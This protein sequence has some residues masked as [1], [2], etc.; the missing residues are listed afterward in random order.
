MTAN[1]LIQEFVD[2]T[3]FIDTHEHIIEET[4]RLVAPNPND[5]RYPCDD[6]AYLFLHYSA[7]DLTSVGMT[8][9]DFARFYGVE[10]TPAEKWRLFE[11]Y[12]ARAKNTGYLQAVRITVRELFGEEDVSA[13]SVERITE[14]MRTLVK[15]GYYRNVLRDVANVDTCQVNSL[16]HV[17][18]E[19]QYPDLL[20]QDL[21][22]VGL[23]TGLDLNLA[24]RANR[25]PVTL[26]DWHAVIDW[27]FETYAARAVAVKNQSA[28]ARRLDYAKVSD[29]DA[30]PLFERFA[31]RDP[32]NAAE[33]KAL[34]DHL[35]HYCVSKATDYGLPVKLHTG[36]Y[37]GANGMPL[38]RLRQ[39]A[40]DLCPVLMAHPRAKFVLMHIGYPYQ[41]EFIALAKQYTNAYVDLCWAWIISPVASVRFLKEALLTAPASKLFSFGGDYITVETVVG[42]ARIARRG[43]AQALTELVD[44]GWLSETDAL[45]AATRIMRGNALDVFDPEGTL[46]AWT[47]QR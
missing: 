18:C 38:E 21:S 3:P 19:T 4:R 11:P 41:D 39:N 14:K 40:G 33:M 1:P 13:E 44:E 36:Y 24:K 2:H 45:D 37:A 31:R 30:A 6:W 20:M 22:F 10:R 16:E 7:S 26:S 12:Y 29:E 17:F 43:I 8:G 46:R 47:P 32:L 9:E 23:S 35:F 15:P 25:E 28:Y 27:Y 34:Q 5:G 42:H